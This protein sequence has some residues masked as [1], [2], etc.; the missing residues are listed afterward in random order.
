M[1]GFQDIVAL[2][3]P[4]LAIYLMYRM[5][6]NHLDHNT[7]VLKELRDA[8]RDLKEWIRDHHNA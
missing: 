4:G 5:S 1:E 6:S 8:I 7:E 3:F 2:G